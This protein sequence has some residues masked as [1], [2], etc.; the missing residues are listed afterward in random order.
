MGCNCGGSRAALGATSSGKP[1]EARP[2]PVA[3]VRPRSKEGPG[4]PGYGSK[5][6]RPKA[7]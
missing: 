3:E 4:T 5:S 6:T 2:R 1:R 7:Q